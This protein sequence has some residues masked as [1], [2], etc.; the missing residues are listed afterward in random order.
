MKYRVACK[1]NSGFF[2]S[3]GKRVKIDDYCET[4][5]YHKVYIGS[6]GRNGHLIKE[7]KRW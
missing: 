7:K 3:E 1:K 6:D 2:G 5:K 4:L